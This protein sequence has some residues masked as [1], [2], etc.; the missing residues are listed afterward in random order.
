MYWKFRK[1]QT[2]AMTDY[3][4]LAP[5]VKSTYEAFEAEI[6]QRTAAFEAAYLAAREV[7]P[8]CAH[9][10]LQT[11]NLEVLAEAED[12]AE[13]LLDRLF[14]LRTESVQAANFFANRSLKD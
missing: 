13:S 9:E 6:D 14:T 3:E 2:L 7:D 5:V 11:F 1:V 8:A 10:L 4:N 12:L